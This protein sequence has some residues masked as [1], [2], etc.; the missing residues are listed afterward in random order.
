M[1][2]WH[3]AAISIPKIRAAFMTLMIRTGNG[4]VV[5]TELSISRAARCGPPQPLRAVAATPS[6]I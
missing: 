6:E 3:P 5:I 4:E 2:L 1:Y